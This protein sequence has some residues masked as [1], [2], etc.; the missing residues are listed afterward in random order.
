MYVND[1]DLLQFLVKARDL[2]LRKLSNRRTGCI[3]IK[4]N[5][6][7]GLPI[8]SDEDYSRTRTNDQFLAIFRQAGFSV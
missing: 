4:E 1:E 2:G 3:F 5:V 6:S 8:Y 7:T